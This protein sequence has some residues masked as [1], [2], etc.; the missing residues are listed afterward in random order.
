MNRRGWI[1]VGVL[2]AACAAAAVLRA[3]IG[4]DGL[5]WPEAEA[6]RQI[7]VQRVGA[8]LVVGAALGLGGVLLQCLLRNPLASP[9]VIGLASGSGLGVMLA[10]YATYLVSQQIAPSSVS[11]GAALA[12]SL[13]TLASVYTLAQRRGRV[14][15]VGLVLIGVIVSIL[16]G[17]A[18]M[19]VQSLLPDRG[20]AASR[21]L[22][23]AIND[24]VQSSTIVGVG[25]IT[26]GLL[27]WAMVAGQ[28]MDAAS[29]GD[30]EA[31]SVGVSLGRLRVQLF[32]AAGV[33]S[34]GSVVL[35][36][37]VGFVGLV[38][39][40]L[41]RLIA[42]PRHRVLA[43]CAALAGATLV[44]AAD[45][46]VKVTDLGSGRLPITVLTSILGGP[47]LIWLLRR[48]SLER[49]AM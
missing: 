33:L 9:D 8:G 46:L 7:R 20:V 17:S 19:L 41:V 38:C 23:G 5:H 13:L 4:P 30:D 24:D 29:L 43:P 3:L 1:L 42:G 39:P 48:E 2:L 45:A 36:G 14:D 21:W 27:V 10:A 18:T 34:A 22:L 35:A 15:P 47:I 6:I 37:P 44:V 26:L 49:T 31:R 40:H 12:G 25:A 28:R 16:C 32:V 11:A